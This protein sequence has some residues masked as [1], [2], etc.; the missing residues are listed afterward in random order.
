MGAA[1]V[2]VYHA[3]GRYPR[4]AEQDALYVMRVEDEEI[5]ASLRFGMEG[6]ETPSWSPDGRRLVFTGLESGVSDLYVINRDG[7]GLERLTSDRYAQRDPVWS[8]DGSRIAFT[9]DFGAGTDF[10]ARRSWH[11][12]NRIRIHTSDRVAEESD[13]DFTGRIR[14]KESIDSLPPSPLR[15]WSGW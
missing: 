15:E 3:I 10:D 4:G 5:V 8:P 12:A 7:S 9:T 13:F 2:I 14:R 6:I 11:D 1:T